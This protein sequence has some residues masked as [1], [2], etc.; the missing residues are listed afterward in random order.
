MV[1]IS[2]VVCPSKN[3]VLGNVPSSRDNLIPLH[4]RG[5]VLL[6]D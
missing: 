6:S 5:G 2:S 1:A 3:F 4:P